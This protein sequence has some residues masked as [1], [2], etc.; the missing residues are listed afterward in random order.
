MHLLATACEDKTLEFPEAIKDHLADLTAVT[1]HPLL[2]ITSVRYAGIISGSGNPRRVRSES[3]HLLAQLINVPF[4]HRPPTVSSRNRLED[5]ADHRKMAD[6][7]GQ[8]RPPA[9]HHDS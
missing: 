9:S 5:I 2:Y 6:E 1:H 8:K 3:L 4:E 7:L